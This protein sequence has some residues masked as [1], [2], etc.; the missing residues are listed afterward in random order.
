MKK[1]VCMVL[2]ALTLSVSAFADEGMW[3]LPLLQKMNGKAMADLG[4][5]LTPEQIYSVNNSSIKDAVVQFGG[6]CTGEIIS[7]E[8]L[9]VTNHHCGYGSIQSLSTPEHNYLEDGFWAMNRSEEIPVPGLTVRFLQRMDDVTKTIEKA[10][11]DATKKLKDPAEIEKASEEA[12]EKAIKELIAKAKEANPTCTAQVVPFYNNNVFYLI[13]SKVY[14]DVRFVGAPPASMGKFGGET[15]NW[16]WPRHTCDFSM[17]RVYAGADNEP[18]DY[19]ADNRP[20]RPRQSL[21][22][23]LKGLE[24]GDFAMIMGYPGRTQRFQTSAQLNEMLRTQDISIGARTVR[25]DLMWEAR[26]ADPVVNLQYANKYAGSAN[27]WK[28]WIAMKQAFDKLGIISRKE[29][30]EADFMQ[31]VGA[32][33]SRQEKYGNALAQIEKGVEESAPAMEALT[34]LS[35]SIGRIEVLGFANSFLRSIAAIK[36]DDM[37]YEEAL[38]KAVEVMGEPLYKDYNEALDRK[39]AAALIAFYRDNVKDE[40]RVTLLGQDVRTMDI[41]AF[42][43]Q[44]F[45]STAFTSAARVKERIK[46]WEDLSNDPASK[47]FADMYMGMMKY[48]QHLMAGQA[49]VAEGSRAFTAGQM[50]W[51]KGEPSYPDANS[52]CRLTYG[53]VKSYSPKDGV[54]YRH[55]TT[56]KGVMEKEDPDNYEFRVPAKLKD[57]Y[58]AKDFGQY[59][60]AAGELPTCFLINCD[61]TGGNSGSPVLD[62]DGALVGLAFDGNWESMSSDVMFEPDLQRCICVDIRYVLLMLDKFGGAGYL[63]DEMNLVR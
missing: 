56:L 16:M 63:L 27:G 48:R 32:K 2:A 8:G 4:C 59:A 43:Q 47:M 45:D 29:Q 5:R 35:E 10:V 22:V 3:L 46:T 26:M 51:K 15:D 36:K 31:W 50:E 55:Y 7:D 24:D 13:V 14:R 11:K 23:S 57:I 53:T 20:M 44:L 9:L 12:A 62:A 1:L 6:G 30:S 49:A 21:K 61:I 19:A 52:T 41:P 18:A 54:L 40:D 25:Q 37:S 58:A 33:K 42:V 39:E 38:T 17:F 34:L 60:N 28:K